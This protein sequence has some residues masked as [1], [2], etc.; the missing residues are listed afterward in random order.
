MQDARWPSHNALCRSTFLV[1]ARL[2]KDELVSVPRSSSRSDSCTSSV[3]PSTL[4]CLRI[5]ACDDPVAVQ[6]AR[7]PI[8]CWWRADGTCGAVDAVG[9]STCG[10]SPLPPGACRLKSEREL[11]EAVTLL[12]SPSQAWLRVEVAPPVGSVGDCVGAV[13]LLIVTRCMTEA[14]CAC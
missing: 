13:S 1:E 6:L 14:C 8:H 3:P 11:P 9:N 4:P 7:W 10:D 2:E 12:R 5:S